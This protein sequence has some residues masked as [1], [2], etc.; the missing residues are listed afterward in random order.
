MRTRRHEDRG[1]TVSTPE[2][3]ASHP[4]TRPK[5]Q[6]VCGGHVDCGL[7]AAVVSR[8]TAP[9]CLRP[10]R[11]TPGGVSEASR[12]S[13]SPCPPLPRIRQTF[14]RTQSPAQQPVGGYPGRGQGRVPRVGSTEGS[15]GACTEGSAGRTALSVTKKEGEGRR[16]EPG[17]PPVSRGQGKEG[18]IHR[19]TVPRTGAV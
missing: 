5:V 4:R 11:G 1:S 15:I 12:G 8:A 10:T 16:L 9:S 2:R 3:D 6:S 18:G 19:S 7:P 14:S 13:T 17:H